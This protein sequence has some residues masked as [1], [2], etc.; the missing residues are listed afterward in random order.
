MKAIDFDVIIQVIFI[1][2]IYV[3]IIAIIV[4]V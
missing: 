4:N 3:F 2:N 1:I